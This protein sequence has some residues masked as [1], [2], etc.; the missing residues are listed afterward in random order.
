MTPLYLEQLKERKQTL[1]I[2][3]LQPYDLSVD[4][5]GLHPLHPFTTADEL[6][7]KTITGLTLLDPRFG[8]RISHLNDQ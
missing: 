4:P 5:T 3:Q 2:A 1:D 6:I 8:K 7:Q